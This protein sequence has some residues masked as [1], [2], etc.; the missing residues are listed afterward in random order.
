MPDQPTDLPPVARPPGTHAPLEAG[1]MVLLR[2]R[3]GR[4]HLVTLEDGGE[5]HSHA[6]ILAHDDLI[7]GPEGRALR[8]TGNMELV[9]LRPTRDDYVLKMKR[10]AQVIY[11]KDL[12]AIL[13]VGDIFPGARVFESGLGSGALSMALLRAGA[14]VLGYEIRADFLARARS[15]VA[16]FA[17]SEAFDRYDTH[18]RDAYAGIDASG[19]DRVLLD[20]PEPWQVVPHAAQ[21]LAP[22]GILVAYTPSVVQVVT[23]RSALDAAGFQMAETLEVLHRA[24]HVEHPAVRP[25]HRMQGHTG[26]L[27]H[28]RLAI[29]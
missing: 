19:L 12:G 7:G 6:G 24:W 13:M 17:G 21:A 29:D 25:V 4:R 26:F 14:S 8:T 5:W 1:E 3:K 10:G 9:V 22:G 15:N 16:R 28:A 11:P 20:L 18:E 2:D 23:L 27:T